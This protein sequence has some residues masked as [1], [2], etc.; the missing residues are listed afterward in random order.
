MQEKLL[1]SLAESS[2]SSSC[3]SEL[4]RLCKFFPIR[5]IEFYAYWIFLIIDMSKV[6]LDHFIIALNVS[7]R[8]NGR[9]IADCLN[10]LYLFHSLTSHNYS[11]SLSS[12]PFYEWF[13]HA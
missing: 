9:N 3:H 2:I 5:H 10:I 1:T 6:C 8:D 13:C 4:S 7:T 11:I 12:S